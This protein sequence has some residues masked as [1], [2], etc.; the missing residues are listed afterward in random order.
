MLVF[1]EAGEVRG[2]AGKDGSAAGAAGRCGAVGVGEEDGLGGE[3][4]EVRSEG[5]GVTTEGTDPV[6]EVIDGDEEDVG[7]RRILN[8]EQ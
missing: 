1:V 7:R 4:L 8:G 3:A 6:V 2:D 5:L